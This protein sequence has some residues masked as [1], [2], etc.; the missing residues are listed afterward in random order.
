MTAIIPFLQ[1]GAFGPDDIKMMSRAL[2]DVCNELGLD[3]NPAAK[4]IV[5]VRIIELARCGE[6]SPI[7]LRNQVPIEA[8]G[9]TGC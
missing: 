9:G 2:D 6:R 5:A 3:D 1:D 7:K 8:R 4:E